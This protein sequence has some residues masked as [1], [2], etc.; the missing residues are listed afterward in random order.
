M[1]VNNYRPHYTLPSN[2]MEL[3]SLPLALTTGVFQFNQMTIMQIPVVIIPTNAKDI[4]QIA[5]MEE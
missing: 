4:E 2:R 1:F 3:S 5:H